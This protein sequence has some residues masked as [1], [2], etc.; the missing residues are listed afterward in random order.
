MPL[1]WSKRWGFFVLI[2]THLLQRHFF[3][4]TSSLLMVMIMISLHF[5]LE[6]WNPLKSDLHFFLSLSVHCAHEWDMSL[7]QQRA[8]RQRLRVSELI[9]R[10]LGRLCFMFRWWPAC[11]YRGGVCL[12]L[13]SHSSGY[14]AVLCSHFSAVILPFSLT[15]LQSM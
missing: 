7:R 5:V 15:A 1:N 8:E 14:H 6:V 11:N 4:S 2:N 12:V 3:C 10:I 13:L 9:G